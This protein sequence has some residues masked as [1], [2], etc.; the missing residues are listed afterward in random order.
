MLR[1]SSCN[2]KS[3]LRLSI[4]VAFFFAKGDFYECSNQRGKEI[5]NKH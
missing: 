2:D 1:Q 4:V 3:L 5:F